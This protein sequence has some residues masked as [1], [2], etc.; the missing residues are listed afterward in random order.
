MATCGWKCSFCLTPQPIITA[1]TLFFILAVVWD[2]YPSPTTQLGCNWE[3]GDSWNNRV[4]G[5]GQLPADTKCF[6]ESSFFS[7]SLRIANCL[8]FGQELCSSTYLFLTLIED[9]TGALRC[10]KLYCVL[11]IPC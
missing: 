2:Y 4:A 7:L 3:I 9:D 6:A 11:K 1:S 5:C 8:N 10:Q